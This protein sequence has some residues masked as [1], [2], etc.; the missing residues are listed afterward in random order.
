M[1]RSINERKWTNDQGHVRTTHRPEEEIK[2]RAAGYTPFED[3]APKGTKIDPKE[4]ALERL[5][6]IHAHIVELDE[7]ADEVEIAGLQEEIAAIAAGQ[8]DLKVDLVTGEVAEEKK[9]RNTRAR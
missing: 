2:L 8:P 9:P 1:S 3:N 6:E 5:A 4:E 7:T